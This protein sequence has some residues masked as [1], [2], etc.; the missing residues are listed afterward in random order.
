[1]AGGGSEAQ[2]KRH[3]GFRGRRVLLEARRSLL[4]RV[5]EEA[6]R[7]EDL[8]E[9]VGGVKTHERQLLGECRLCPGW[10]KGAVANRGA[11]RGG[12]R[13]RERCGA[14]HGRGNGS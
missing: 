4:I 13:N 5:E 12:K 11:D 10:V 6:V 7:A 3:R 14:T 1:M 9:R 2:G 8:V